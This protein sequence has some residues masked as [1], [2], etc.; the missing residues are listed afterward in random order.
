L[1]HLKEKE[2]TDMATTKPIGLREVYLTQLDA[3]GAPVVGKRVALPASRIFSFKPKADVKRLEGGDVIV[4]A[5]DVNKG[6]DFNI[7]GGGVSIDVLALLSGGTVATTGTGA[8]EVTELT[9]TSDN[10]APYFQVEGRS[11]NSSGAGD[12]VTTVFYARCT[13]G[14][15]EFTQNNGEYFLTKAAGELFEHPTN[16]KLY[17]TKQRVTAAALPTT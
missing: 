10:T 2:T 15:P 5:V 9:V 6:G 17:S 11:V 8:T 3:V 12:L 16:K 13:G 1:F 7:E 14:G 4:D